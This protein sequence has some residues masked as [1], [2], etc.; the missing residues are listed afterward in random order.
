[1]SETKKRL[2]ALLSASDR[3][4]GVGYTYA[5]AYR[6]ALKRGRDGSEVARELKCTEA[7]AETFR[8]F[9][10]DVLADG[11][12][13]LVYGR[14]LVSRTEFEGYGKAAAKRIKS[15]I[16]NA[17]GRLVVVEPASS[18]GNGARWVCQCDC[19]RRVEVQGTALRAGLVKSC[20]CMGA[21]CDRRGRWGTEGEPVRPSR[22]S[23]VLP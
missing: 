23:E 22:A 15:E 5:E 20:G 10:P 4:L 14:V 19:G 7:A 3:I 16:G 1:M 8:E 6:D 2:C 21:F 17:F 11:D 12:V 18:R 13:R 9:G